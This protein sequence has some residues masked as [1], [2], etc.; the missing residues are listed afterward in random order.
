MAEEEDEDKGYEAEEKDILGKKKRIRK[1]QCSETVAE[2]EKDDK[3]YEAEE[4]ERIG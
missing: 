2:E 4:K 3:G 1:G